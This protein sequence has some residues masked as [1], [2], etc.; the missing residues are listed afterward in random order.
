MD[1]VPSKPK[2][3]EDMKYDDYRVRDAVDTLMRAEEIKQDP[4][5]MKLV[6]AEM[7]KKHKAIKKVSSI[8]ELRHLK[9]KMADDESAAE[10]KGESAQD[11]V[12]EEKE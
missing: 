4:K 10:E 3:D 12:D 7:Q 9:N 1:A 6:H 11:E 8:K 2:S 5:M